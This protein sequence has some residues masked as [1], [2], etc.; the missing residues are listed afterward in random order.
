[1]S[2]DLTRIDNLALDERAK[3]GIEKVR[4]ARAFLEPLLLQ[5]RQT[6]E[7]R[8]TLTRPPNTFP[9]AAEK[10][11]QAAGDHS[12]LAAAVAFDSEAVREDLANARSLLALQQ[13]LETLSQLVADARLLSLHEAFVASLGLYAVAKAAAPHNKP[14]ATLIAPL[15]KI[16]DL[17]RRVVVEPVV[18]EV[19]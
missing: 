16:F 17:G 14:V 8:A 10:L 1:M 18:E 4:E 12:S 7:S 2:K 9:D 13:E 15:G 5:T 3:K 11:A 6:K 19:A